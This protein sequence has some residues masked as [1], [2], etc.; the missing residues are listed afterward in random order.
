MPMKKKHLVITL[1]LLSFV[2]IP[3]SDAYADGGIKGWFTSLFKKNTDTNE[4]DEHP[5]LTVL[6]IEEN[7]EIPELSNKEAIRVRGIQKTEAERLKA[8]KGF[9]IEMMRNNEVIRVTIPASSLF[10]P[11]DTSLHVNA[12]AMLRPLLQCL[13]TPD[14]YHVLLVMHSDNTGNDAYTY[15][16]TTQ[17]VLAVF[18]W[19]D[20]NGAITDF[21]V[22]YAA[23]SHEPLVPNNSVENR[24]KN[25]R[26][27]IYLI[28]AEAM[29]K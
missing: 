2:C 8:T 18:D 19:L 4:T 1:I 16:L 24:S 21:V 26:L 28:P 15:E 10:A 9:K 6:T 27:E 12:D 20:R 11:N 23:G 3:L 7:L 25:R 5:D 29:L 17:R 14:Y 22:P 13:R